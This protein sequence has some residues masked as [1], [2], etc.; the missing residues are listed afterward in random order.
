MF[1]LT[2]SGGLASSHTFTQDG[3]GLEVTAGSFSNGG[4]TF[5]GGWVGR[6]SS[7]LGVTNYYGDSHQVDGR[8]VNDLLFFNFDQNVVLKSVTFSY[9]E[10][11]D[12]FRFFFQSGGSGSLVD[13]GSNVDIPGSNFYSTYVFA[14]EWIGENFGIGAAGKRDDFKVKKVTVE[15]YLAIPLPAAAPL[16]AGGLGLLGLLG[17]RRRRKTRTV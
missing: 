3:I 12:D 4:Q 11:G 15:S 7:G 6:Y 10:R 5:T 2:G 9:N 17:L 8:H 1:N 16:L 14:N 13:W